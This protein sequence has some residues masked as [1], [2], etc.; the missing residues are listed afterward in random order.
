MTQPGPGT[1]VCLALAAATAISA[2]GCGGGTHPLD[3]D[4]TVEIFTDTTGPLFARR[5]EEYLTGRQ[6]PYEMNLT[7]YMSRNGKPEHGAYVDVRVNPGPALSLHETD[8]T[9]KPTDGAFR[10]TG[11]GEGYA[12]FLVRSDSDWAGTARVVVLWANNTE[13]LD[14]RIKP[15]GLP[16]GSADFELLAEGTNG[17]EAA[18]IRPSYPFADLCSLDNTEPQQWPGKDLPIRKAK[19]RV[20]ALAPLELPGVLE[21]APVVLASDSTEAEFSTSEDCTNRK[22]RLVVQLNATGESPPSWVCFS[23]VG[24]SIAVGARSGEVTSGP[25]R[26]FI[27]DPEPRLIKID[28]LVQSVPVGT[29][30]NLWQVLV[31]GA[32]SE[33]PIALAVSVKSIGVSAT[34]RQSSAMTSAD[35]NAPTAVNLT[36]W[37]PGL[38][39]VRIAPEFRPDKGCDSDPIP[40]LE[41]PPGGLQ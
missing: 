34:L 28:P 17:T 18:R 2:T 30:T 8:G 37:Q 20:R 3:G 33:E 29:E 26:A 13:P 27:V 32:V 40:A 5:S 11:N 9:C 10:C 35:R 1:W 7:L 14:V 6:K 16:E 23:N 19:L 24:G 4:G 21:N 38:A 25:A 36:V 15:A 39:R 22:T 41:D 31:Y 12:H